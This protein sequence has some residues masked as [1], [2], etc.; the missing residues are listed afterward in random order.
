MNS[1]EEVI[2]TIMGT[3]DTIKDTIIPPTPGSVVCNNCGGLI[4]GY[5]GKATKCTFC[6]NQQIIKE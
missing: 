3:I 6:E 2:K 4:Q 1:P 5:V